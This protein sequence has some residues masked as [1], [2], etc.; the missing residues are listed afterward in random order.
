MIATL[1]GRLQEVTAAGVIL[2]ISGIGF[3][4]HVPASVRERVHPGDLLF[5]HTCLVVRQELLA[6]YGFET[7]EEREFFSLLLTVDGVGPKSALAMLSVLSPD[8]IRRAVFQAQPDL[9][10]RVPGVGKKTAQKI[11]LQLQD[12]L[13]AAAGFDRLSQISEADAEVLAA[14]TTLGY[15]VVEAQ[16]ALQSIPRDAPQEVEERLRLALQYFGG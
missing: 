5:L 13:P 15:S 2:E 8:A 1:N 16:L 12:R 4:V 11:F 14:L 10:T 7:L 3:L 6:L 9:F